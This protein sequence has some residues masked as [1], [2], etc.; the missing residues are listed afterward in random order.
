MG[1]V[2]TRAAVSPWEA[3]LLQVWA[4]GFWLQG[5]AHRSCWCAGRRRP[6]SCQPSRAIARPGLRVAGR[7][8]ESV[9]RDRVSGV[10]APH[11]AVRPDDGACGLGDAPALAAGEGDHHP[12]SVWMLGLF[13][14]VGLLSLLRPA[15]L[16]VG[17]LEWVKWLQI[18]LAMCLVFDRIAKL[19]DRGGLHYRCRGVIGIRAC[20]G[21][22]RALAV[23]HSR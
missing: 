23:C 14:F 20:T 17:F 10:G 16:W 22:D 1:S 3:L 6:C 18:L 8:I 12:P 7:A 9:A 4:W 11:R 13:I 15:D 19:G 21:G 5:T 2:R